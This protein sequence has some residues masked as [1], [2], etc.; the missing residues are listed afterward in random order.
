MAERLGTLTEI[1]EAIKSTDVAKERIAEINASADAKKKEVLDSIPENYT[2]LLND[3]NEL[4]EDLNH[5]DIDNKFNKNTFTSGFYYNY[6]TGIKS[7][8]GSFSY[9]ENINIE[10]FK[11][12]YCSANNTHVCFFDNADTFISG[13]ICNYSGSSGTFGSYFTPPAETSYAIFSM[14]TTEIPNAKLYKE[15]NTNKIVTVDI[16]GNGDY[17]SV[18]DAVANEEENTVIF[19]KP[20]IYIGTVEAFTKRII[21][22]GADKNT[23]IIKSRSGS[24]SQPCVN[25]S[26]GYF[27]NLTF[28]AEYV[29]GISNEIPITADTAS[30]AFHC[31][32]EY[33]VGK[34]LEFHHCI[35]KSDFFSALGIGVRKDFTLIIDNCELINNQT[36]NRG[37]NYSNY[38]S[39][40]KG[41]GALF[42]HDSV[43]EQGNSYVKIKDT[44]FK[45]TL[46]Y[47]ICLYNARGG[48]NKVYCEFINNTIYDENS[49]LTNNL[50][51][52]GGSFEEVFVINAISHG[53]TN[54]TLNNTN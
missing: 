30:Y 35:L 10:P 50:F 17:T 15:Q 12:Y 6:L 2:D 14:A 31:E 21:L 53:N 11:K 3:V 39:D 23:C 41:L 38:G 9:S 48:N 5:Y 18:V 16:N 13:T 37:P 33:G 24:Y 46:G 29:H 4:K 1:A 36:V 8:L 40:G 27:E 47:S 52:R 45:S 51:K 20:G 34:T 26:C 28:Y 25:G 19:I 42:L 49:G 44:V 22:I 54:E 43:G 32:N 7:A